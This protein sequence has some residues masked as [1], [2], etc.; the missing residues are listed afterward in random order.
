MISAKHVFVNM[1]QQWIGFLTPRLSL[2]KHAYLIWKVGFYRQID[3]TIDIYVAFSQ[4]VIC[5]FQS[6]SIFKDTL[7]KQGV[8][9]D[10]I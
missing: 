10:Q 8:S 6:R 3:I 1:I 9:M 5:L 7:H 2:R 4:L